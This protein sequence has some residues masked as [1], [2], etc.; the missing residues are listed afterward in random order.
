MILIGIGITSWIVFDQLTFRRLSKVDKAIEIYRRMRHYVTRLGFQYEPGLTPYEFGSSF[1]SWFLSHYAFSNGSYTHGTF[2]S[3]LNNLIDKIVMISCSSENVQ[4]FDRIYYDWKSLRKQLHQ[5]WLNM[6]FI[7]LR[8]ELIF[9]MS[10]KVQSKKR[11]TQQ[12]K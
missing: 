8:N 2:S 10:G 12:V 3:Q 1:N 4:D 6:K 7:T 5:A 9:F 11:F